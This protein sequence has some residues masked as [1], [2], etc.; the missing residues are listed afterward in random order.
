VGNFSLQ[1][2]R[3]FAD[4]MRRTGTAAEKQFWWKLSRNQ[5]RYRFQRQQLLAGYIVDFYCAQLKL[6]VEIDG[7]IHEREDVAADDE[8]RDRILTDRGYLILR[9]TNQDVLDHMTVVLMRLWNECRRRRA[10][11][12]AFDS[13]SVFV[14]ERVKSRN[15]RPCESV[16][17]PLGPA[18]VDK[19]SVDDF[20]PLP[21][22]TTWKTPA[23]AD[24]F[25]AI[26]KGW[27]R[28]IS[29][30]VQ[31]QPTMRERAVCE[32]LRLREWIEEKA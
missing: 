24:D 29:A 15:Y 30:H 26:A 2:K 31:D 12:K 28:L 5:F 7:S 32:R 27:Q 19:V 18:T 6:I 14:R 1:E 11:L 13:S 21:V 20:A 4:H 25:R 23:S 10:A 17:K 22:N 8:Q 16:E 9:F 3:D